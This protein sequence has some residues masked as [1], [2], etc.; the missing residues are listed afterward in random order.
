MAHNEPTKPA[1]PKADDAAWKAIVVKFQKPSIASAIWQITNTLVPIAV[2]WYLMY[3]SIPISWWLVVPQAIL[4]G[5][6]LIRV[7][8]IFH[9]CG[10]G[11]Y[12][13]SRKA[14]DAVG[15]ITGIL[16]FTPYYH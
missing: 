7:F 13:K 2:L 6:L 12:F 5:G 8:I 16:T 10:H 9:D 15:F 11:S 4:V 3:L 14:N 1:N